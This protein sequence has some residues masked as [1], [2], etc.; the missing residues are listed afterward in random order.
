M[1]KPLL[2][3][4]F[5]LF[6]PRGSGKTTLLRDFFSQE[7]ALWIDLLKEEEVSRF[8]RNPN[9]LEQRIAH[10]SPLPDWVVIDEIQ[11]QPALLDE[12]HRM[13]ENPL[14][15][16]KI[17]FA[18]TGSS[19][20][21]LKRGAAN[22]LAGRA[23]VN[24]LHPLISQELGKSFYLQD[25]LQWGTLPK[26]FDFKETLEKREYLRAYSSTYLKEEIKEEQLVRRIDPFRRFLEVVAQCNG[27]I[28]NYSKIARDA[29]TDP[30]AVERYFEILE[31][32]LLGFFLDP[33][34]RSIR[35]RQSKRSKFY[36]FDLGV[37]KALEFTLDVPLRDGTY[38]YGKAFEHFIILECMRLNDYLRKDFRFSYLRTKDDLEIDLII[39]RPGKKL[40]LVEIKSASNVD[41]IDI[42]KVAS[43]S[44]D[45]P[46]AE[47]FILC[48]EAIPRQSEG[49]TVIPW[50]SGL[51]EIFN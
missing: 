36:F 47:T 31:D 35:K 17:K 4:S 24:H 44:K 14:T 30:K 39:E 32:T 37:K 13:I 50:K 49:V 16:G 34:H 1:C 2:S 15:W 12:V 38:A 46:E 43:I 18:L 22:L 25:A 20:R 28:L 48:Q 51:E 3:N 19:A 29:A 5:F 10:L 27:E 40:A 9:E 42:R 33:Y 7:K 11:K 23:F 26:I 8:V 21:K 6:G 41:D 45:V